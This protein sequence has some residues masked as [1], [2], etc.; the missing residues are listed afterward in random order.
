MFL[1]LTPGKTNGRV[2][3]LQGTRT[4]CNQTY[5][6]VS[7]QTYFQTLLASMGVVKGQHPTL[8]GGGGTNECGCVLEVKG[9]INPLSGGR[10]RGKRFLR[11]ST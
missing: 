6:E 11:T 7:Q 10:G 8:W 4:T 9:E 2:P 3:S 5:W 1:F